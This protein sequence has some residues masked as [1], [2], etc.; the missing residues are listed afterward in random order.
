MAVISTDRCNIYT[1]AL[2]K[3]MP[4]MKQRPASKAG[5]YRVTS[6]ILKTYAEAHQ[7]A[8]A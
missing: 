1:L 8:I 2:E 5:P 6:R 4:K 7:K 3:E